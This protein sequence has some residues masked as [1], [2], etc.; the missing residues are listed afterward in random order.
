MRNG[1]SVSQLFAFNFVPRGARTSTL[2]TLLFAVTAFSSNSIGADPMV[3]W[4]ESP[5]H[6]NA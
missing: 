4:G 5:R 1:A 2:R 3:R 6:N